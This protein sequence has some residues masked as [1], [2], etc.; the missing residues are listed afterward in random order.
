M[1]KEVATFAGGCF[2]CMVKPFDTLPGILSVVSGYAG[3]HV[4]HPTYEMVKSG[5]TGHVE[6]VQITYDSSIMS[7]DDLLTI[8]WQQTDPTDAFGQFVDKGSMYQPVIFYHNEE[9]QHKAQQSKENLA[10]SGRFTDP[11]VTQIKP[12][13]NFYPAE[14]Y[15]QQFYKKSSD[16]YYAYRNA[17]GRDTFIAENWKK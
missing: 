7:Y 12:F 11:I 8:Y 14:E 16:H 6:V 3:G 2:W 13:T 5:H 17:S 1:Q 15:H 9:Q 4:E 10:N